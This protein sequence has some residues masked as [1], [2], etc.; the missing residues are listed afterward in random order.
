MVRGFVFGKFLPF[1][2]GHQALI[3]F[4]AGK[5]DE[6]LVLVCAGNLEKLSGKV[7]TEWISDTYRNHSNI[8]VITFEYDASELPNT[9]ESSKEISAMWAA[10]FLEILPKSDVLFT[11]E[12]YGEY[13]ADFMGIKHQPFD[14]NR[15]KKPISATQ[16]RSDVIKFWEYLPDIV[17]LHYQ[18]KV[19]VLGT[20]SVGKTTLIEYLS[21]QFSSSI[22]HELGRDLIP[23][24]KQLTTDQ[25]KLVASGHAQNI[26]NATQELKPLIF[27][28]TDVHITQSYARHFFGEYLNLPESVYQDNQADLYLY[29]NNNVP[30]VQDGTR[31]DESERNALDYS[32]RMTIARFGINITE[33]QGSY[34]VINQKAILLVKSL[35]D[36]WY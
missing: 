32:H 30:Y 31:L 26:R 9:S 10:K 11:S 20:E 21:K 7:R 25:L 36:T 4:G 16:I 28:D 27:I 18:Q 1:H 35:I 15:L 22:V 12:P 17:K 19:V 2:K 14:P 29:L 34:E 8:R 33:L 6:L 23:D 3:E 5:C 24:S 13:V